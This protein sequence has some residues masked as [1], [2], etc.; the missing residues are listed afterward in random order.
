MEIQKLIEEHEQVVKCFK[1]ECIPT[2]EQISQMCSEAL[3]RGNKIMLCGNGGSAADS[4]HI[5]A[6]FVGRFH[7]ERIS[8]PAIA[9]TTD[10]SILTA[11]ANDYSYED[12]FS[13][14]V[15]GLGEKGDVLIGIS[16]S[17]NSKNVVKAFTEAKRKGIFTVAF[18]G[19]KSSK[20]SEMADV[21]LR[22]PSSVTARIQECHILSGHII[23]AFVDEEY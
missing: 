13:R 18:T 10:T 1:Q 7:K 23:C 15:E 17:G 12:V 20:L 21:T 16:T 14:Q 11:V 5:A 8:L 9:L 22:V 3:H 6:E 4:Q 19:E 2:L